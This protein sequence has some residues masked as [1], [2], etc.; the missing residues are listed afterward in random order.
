MFWSL[1]RVMAKFNNVSFFFSTQ[2]SENIGFGSVLISKAVHGLHQR[3]YFFF[4]YGA[5]VSI[6]SFRI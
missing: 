3:L 1:H 6:L 2:V 4:P 5:S